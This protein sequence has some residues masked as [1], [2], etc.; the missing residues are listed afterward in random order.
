LPSFRFE[1]RVIYPEAPFIIESAAD[2]SENN[3]QA[4]FRNIKA[5][6]ADKRKTGHLKALK[7][8]SFWWRSQKT[9]KSRG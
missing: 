7:A 9:G 3:E 8:I 1:C 2:K 6:A 5:T 4:V